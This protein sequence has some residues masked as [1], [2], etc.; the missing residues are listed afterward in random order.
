MQV[1]SLVRSNVDGAV[2]IVT[3]VKPPTAK[4]WRTKFRVLFPDYHTPMWLS[5][6]VL[7][8]ICK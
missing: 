1:G 4:D 8:V 3:E 7:E 2:G 5:S 6:Q